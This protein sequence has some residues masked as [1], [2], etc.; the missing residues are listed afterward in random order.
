[1]RTDGRVI[2]EVARDFWQAMG[3]RVAVGLSLLLLGSLTEGISI[4]MLVPVVQHFSATAGSAAPPLPWL[5]ELFRAG[6]FGLA[7]AL[8]ALIGIVTLQTVFM[9]F[10]D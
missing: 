8:A 4:V 5:G 7:G 10:K 3:W 1:M 9:R 6:N 2:F